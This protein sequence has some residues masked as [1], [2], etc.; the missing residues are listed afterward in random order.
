[1][2]GS[3]RP[4]IAL[5]A[6]ASGACTSMPYK[7]PV[8]EAM[9][10]STAAFKGLRDLSPGKPLKVLVV[11]GMCS[12][13]SSWAANWRR[14]LEQALATP[15]KPRPSPPVGGILTERYD[16]VGPK[17][18]IEV[19][20]AIW[21]SA[22]QWPKISLYYD[23][24]PDFRFKRAKFNAAAKETLIND[25]FA[26]PIIYAGSQGTGSIGAALR[27]DMAH[28]V[29]GF[30]GGRWQDDACNGGDTGVD[31][32]FITESLGSKML[33][34]AVERVAGHRAETA[35]ATRAA[36]SR[37]RAIYM[38]A[39]QIPL[40]RLADARTTAQSWRVSESEFRWFGPQSQRGEQMSAQDRLQLVAF[41]DPNDQFSYRLTHASLRETPER[42][43]LFN[44]IV[45]NDKTYFGLAEN[46]YTA[47][48]NYWK[49]PTVPPLVLYGGRATP[50]TR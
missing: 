13:D 15:A 20:F 17:R 28:L 35:D 33:T 10:P 21:S 50:P 47:H 6:L 32:A 31:S 42:V 41:T 5:C 22:T 3:W 30:L 8:I 44:V 26:D 14:N 4:T 19:T 23:S 1:M 49:N 40:L 18:T 36:L 9:A 43:D 12:H 45:S 25:C 2:N 24:P 34:D 27:G 7:T 46:P 39:N 16:F 48:V 11:H 29:C 38:L 37:T